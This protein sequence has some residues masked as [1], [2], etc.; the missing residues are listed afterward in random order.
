M[1]K[2][3]REEVLNQKTS[4]LLKRI[5]VLE[6]A[7]NRSEVNCRNLLEHTGVGICIFDAAGKFLAMNKAMASITGYSQTEFSRGNM[8]AIYVNPED[9]T[10]FIDV[11]NRDGAMEN[12]ETLWMDNEGEQY[13]V[14]LS[15]RTITYDGVDA[16]LT[17]VLDISARK[18]AEDALRESEAYLNEAQKIAHIGSWHL[19]LASNRLAWTDEIY[20][21]F[22][23]TKDVP[24]TYEK[25]LQ[26]V[27]HEDREYVN[28]NW[29]K[30]VFQGSPYDIE[31]RIVVGD[32]VKW[33]RE[34]AEILYDKAGRALRG[35][36]TVQDITERVQGMKEK[37]WCEKQLHQAQKLKSIGRLAGGVAHDFNNM[38][39][40]IVGHTAL[41]LAKVDPSQQLFNHLEEIRG[42]AVRSSNLTRQLLAF[43][44]KQP[45]LPK[46]LD[47][48]VSI[49]GMLNMLQR[50]I[51]E[52]I[53]LVWLPAAE[54][55]HILMDPSQIDQIL[56]NL[57]INARDA[58]QGVG[59]VYVETKNVTLERAFCAEMPNTVT[60][61]Y[62]MLAVSDD[63]CG[64]DKETQSKVFEPFFTT[65]EVGTGTGL[66][67][68]TVYGIVKQNGGF[69][70]IYSEPGKGTTFKVYLPRHTAMIDLN[71]EESSKIPPERGS[72]TILIVD[73]EPAIIKIITMMLEGLGYAVLAAA[74]PSEAMHLARHHDGGIHL[75]IT[76]VIMPGM[77]GRELAENLMHICPSIKCLFISGY[78]NTIIAHHGVL[79]EGVNFIQ[80]PIS[81]DVLAARIREVLVVG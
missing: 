19:D 79:D 21:I 34:R 24:L 39:T 3:D 74:T 29:Q 26:Y 76:D 69:I 20:R 2:A 40:V 75:L 33:V 38:L 45:I 50:L 15:G 13:W 1:A 78:T 80:K 12:F 27:H 31:H 44:S 17:T 10:R 67:M 36:G 61:D 54:G 42:A 62:I 9:Q 47:L 5:V 58:I 51:G 30:T 14:S 70:N 28:T 71:E 49:E 43:A 52:N 35:V 65:K 81:M 32:K 77:S 57:C 22:G 7:L 73:D 11:V 46:L 18:T 37:E 59:A 23:V 68:S 25:F 72:E 53:K 4:W 63:G 55:W 48:N 16:F 6:E 66:G 60:G 64:M 41:A 56:A 8:V